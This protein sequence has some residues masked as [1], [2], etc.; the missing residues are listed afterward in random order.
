MVSHTVCVHQLVEIGH[1]ERQQALLDIA[2]DHLGEE[3]IVDPIVLPEI[4]QNVE[5]S[6]QALM[7]VGK[8]LTSNELHQE[9]D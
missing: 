3:P 4:A 6:D 1:Q 5:A 9:V 7:Y 8:R 2:R